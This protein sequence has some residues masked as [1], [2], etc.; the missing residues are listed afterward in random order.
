MAQTQ[1][2]PRLPDPTKQ[3]ILASFDD[4]LDA[5][6][7]VDKL[8]DNKFAVQGVAIVGVDLKMVE[9]VLGRMSWGRAAFGGLMTG[10]WLGLLLGLFISIFAKVEDVSQ[11]ELVLLGLVYGAAAGIIFGLVSYGVTGGKRDFVSRSQLRASKYNIHVDQQVIGE[12][13]RILGMSTA[14]PPPLDDSAPTGAT[15]LTEPAPATTPPPESPTPPA[16]PSAPPTGGPL[17]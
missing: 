8:S 17:S 11:W 3:P 10:A 6:A 1:L 12:A 2:N 14:W 9:T 5:Q 15:S 7:A 4:Y 16:T 13:R